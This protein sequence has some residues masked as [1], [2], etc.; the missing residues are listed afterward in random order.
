MGKLRRIAI[1]SNGIHENTGYSGQIRSLIP[2][3]R[4]E[5]YEVAVIANSGLSGQ[6]IKW[7]GTDIYPM[8]GN[9]FDFRLAGEYIRHFK[10][11]VALSLYDM[12]PIPEQARSE[13]G[14]P[15][16]AWV[17]VDGA[18][19]PERVLASTR[20]ADWV[21][22]MS[23]FGQAE[24]AAAG[25]ESECVQLGIDCD[26]YCPGEREKARKELGFPDGAFVVGVVAANKGWPSRKSWPEL[27]EG[28]AQFHRRFPRNTIL[29]LHTTALPYGTH[30]GANI[31]RLRARVGL[32]QDVVKMTAESDIAI[33]I[34]PETMAQLYRAFDVL[35]C[36]SMG[37][38][39]G[40]PVVEAQACGTP[41]IT[42]DCTAM[43]ENTFL[44]QC[45]Q[46][47]QQFYVPQ[48][49]YFWW[50]ASVQRIAEALATAYHARRDEREVMR[51]VHKVR[52]RY[53]WPDL[54][55]RKWKP[56]L[57]KVEAELW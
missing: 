39:F 45:I 38:G 18:P 40:L 51:A 50:L 10:A 22:S 46:P 4:G 52:Q 23:A 6:A 55:E 21:L 42:Q 33:G 47:L 30:E 29:Y 7:Q 11:D 27:M 53:H 48:L 5:G 28:F 31:P 37:E 41:V 43:P 20:K 56:Y 49:D 17:P 15:W 26:V 54:F 24:L 25:V 2:F 14:V 57:E 1:Y 16:I 13:M 36:P 12:F 9:P 8:R 34:Q 44:G 35:L 19:V 3:L 32:A